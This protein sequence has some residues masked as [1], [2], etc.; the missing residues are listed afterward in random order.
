MND[1]LL[2]LLNKLCNIM[3]KGRDAQQHKKKEIIMTVISTKMTTYY[4]NATTGSVDVK[5]GWYYKND[6]G[7]V[8]NAVDRG[9]VV[10][11]V[12]DENGDWT[13]VE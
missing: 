12:K 6:S 10:E 7:E 8:V 2:D 4:M 3:F 9:E 5:D 11:V 1:L 13:E